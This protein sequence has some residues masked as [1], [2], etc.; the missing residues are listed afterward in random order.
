[1]PTKVFISY[2]CGD[3]RAMPGVFMIGWSANSGSIS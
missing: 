1:M 2:R 3:S